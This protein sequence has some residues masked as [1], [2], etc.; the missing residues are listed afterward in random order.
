MRKLIAT[1]FAMGLAAAVSAEPGQPFTLQSADGTERTLPEQQQG[2]GL[3]LFWATWCPYCKA[4]MPHLQS[5]EDEYGERVTV[6]ALNFRD[7]SDPRDY[8]DEHGFDFVLFPDAGEVAERWGAHATPALYVV[9]EDGNVV[10][11][12][13]EVLT[14]D[15]PGDADLGH[16]QRAARRAP[17]WAARIREALDDLLAPAS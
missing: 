5:I 11:D 1:L 13:Y 12:L 15:P 17:F 6:Y 9:D 8:V 4:L 14:E 16:T 3:Y 10:F 7:K 2:V